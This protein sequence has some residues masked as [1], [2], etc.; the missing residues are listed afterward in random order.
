M[1]PIDRLREYLDERQ[2]DYT[3]VRHRRD[4][5]ARETAADTRTPPAE[6]AKTVF[7]CI[8]R[9]YA[10]AVLRADDFVSEEKLRLA[11]RAE[12]VELADE[13]EILDLIPDCEV[14]AAP[15]FGNLWDLPVYASPALADDETITFNAGT[16]EDAIRMAF[17]D[18]KHL[19]R[20]EVVP[21]ARHD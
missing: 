18:W 7:L 4:F 8:D 19:V 2:V 3:V 13:D 10:M 11:L 14:G 9:R 17:A 12:A 16:H 20:P 5:T 1:M 21:L 6:F 15:P